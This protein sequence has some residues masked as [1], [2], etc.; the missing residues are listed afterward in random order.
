MRVLFCGGPDIE[1][2]LCARVRLED[3]VRTMRLGNSA[4]VRLK[5]R[6]CDPTGGLDSPRYN[7]RSELDAPCRRAALPALS[8]LAAPN[9]FLWF[10]EISKLLFD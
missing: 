8:F 2:E 1:E 9:L 7:S 6:T 3:F 4:R 10:A 5:R